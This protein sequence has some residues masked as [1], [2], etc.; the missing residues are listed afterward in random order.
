[1]TSPESGPSFAKTASTLLAV[2]AFVS[3]PSRADLVLKDSTY[4]PGTIIEDTVTHLD[5]LKLTVTQN[6]SFDD[7][8][9]KFGA[10][11]E[12]GGFQYGDVL[13]VGQ[14]FKDGGLPS[15]VPS[16]MPE[17]GS[18]FSSN[19]SDV[20]AV[21]NLITLFGS[22][23]SDADHPIE[24]IGIIGSH[25]LFGLGPDEIDFAA[26]G[27]QTTLACAVVHCAAA[28]PLSGGT[29]GPGILDTPFPQSGSFLFESAPAAVPE[30]SFTILIGIGLM[31]IVLRKFLC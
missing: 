21:T 9:S 5:W 30:P 24:S 1:M 17:W 16:N 26:L 6:R 28:E 2:A 14:L 27:V 25:D 20:A 19:P 8:S 7:V 12:F 3:L 18:L 29:S 31:S 22:T 10:G 11:E 15:L 4:G 13:Q 23:F